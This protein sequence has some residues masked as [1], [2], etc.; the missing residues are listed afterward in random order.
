VRLLGAYHD[1]WLE[2]F[3]PQVYSYSL[4]NSNAIGGHF[5]WRY[6]E[7]RLS[8]AGHLIHE[9]E[10]AGAAGFEARWVIE[11]SDAIF[12]AVPKSEA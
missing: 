3:Y 12:T 7:F 6:A 11:A 1:Y 8:Q 10:W 5:D 4:T 9:I 2:F